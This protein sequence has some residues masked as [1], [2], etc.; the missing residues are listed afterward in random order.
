[1]KTKIYTLFSILFLGFYAQKAKADACQITQLSVRQVSLPEYNSTTNTTT[2]TFDLGYN[3][4]LNGG[5]KYT[6][7]N[8]WLA[9]NYVNPLPVS[10]NQ[11]PP[12]PVAPKL[13]NVSGIIVI[14]ND[15][16]MDFSTAYNVFQNVYAPANTYDSKVLDSLDGLR[17]TKVK[18]NANYVRYFIKNVKITI[19]GNTS[20]ISM[21]GDVW[22]TQS[23]N[24]GHV[25]CVYSGFNLSINDP[26]I[27]GT[28]NCKGTIIMPTNSYSVD[29]TYNVQSNSLTG[30]N[31]MRGNI[32]VYKDSDNDGF[33]TPGTDAQVDQVL[34]AELNSA[35]NWTATATRSYTM[36][37]FPAD[38]TRKLFIQFEDAYSYTSSSDLNPSKVENALQAVLN[39]NCLLPIELKSFSGTRISKEDVLMK[40]TAIETTTQDKYE[41]Q[42]SDDGR[43][44][45]TVTIIQARYE[46]GKEVS[47]SYT[48]KNNSSKYTLYR[49]NMINADGKPSYSNV[50]NI[51]GTDK[52][53]AYT[54]AP[55]PSTD[56]RIQVR[57]SSNT[58]KLNIYV[59]DNIGRL[60]NKVNNVLSG[61]YVVDNLQNGIYFVKIANDAGDVSTVEKVAIQRR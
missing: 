21:K 26:Y 24:A 14:D 39:M 12:P 6:Y 4:A 44:W 1:M 49:L 18:I 2:F 22:Q 47:Y 58:M 30:T 32:R 9:A 43:N 46:A 34:N 7:I 41:L 33:F 11:M 50:V 45:T 23:A 28:F 37:D 25:H 52:Q 35:N 3:A 20:N 27:N 5:A 31:L 10:G 8:L 61:N 51:P 13:D 15:Y 42:R 16:A 36:T 60:V 59:F 56:G 53:Y 54:I 57:I 38:A 17:F 55:N 48:D 40:W 19:P 29:Y